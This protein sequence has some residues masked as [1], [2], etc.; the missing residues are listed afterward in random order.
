MNI[1]K[2][3]IVTDT[4]IVTDLDTCRLLEK[5][6]ALDNVYMC[7]MVKND[8]INDK[9]GNVN[10]IKKFKTIEVNIEQLEEIFVIDKIVN[11]L[12]SHDIINFIIARDNNA[13][14]AT[15]DRKLRNF[16]ISNNVEVIRTLKII[17]LMKINNIINFKEVIQALELLKNNNYTRIP[18][19]E[20]DKLLTKYKRELDKKVTEVKS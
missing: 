8:E 16:S 20:I 6:V 14:L 11:G 3:I 10:I 5:F 1:T 9:T 18:Y 19:E 13:M 15:G 7:D 12:T 4:N 2:K 17:E